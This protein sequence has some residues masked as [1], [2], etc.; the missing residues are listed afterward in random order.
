MLGRIFGIA[1]R[2]IVRTCVSARPQQNFNLSTAQFAACRKFSVTRPTRAEAVK[3][4]A[5][6][7]DIDEEEAEDEAEDEKGEIYHEAPIKLYS[8]SGEIATYIFQSIEDVNVTVRVVNELHTFYESTLETPELEEFLNDPALK[9]DT[10]Y[11]LLYKYGDLVELSPYTRDILDDL[12]EA[13]QFG[14]LRAVAE[15]LL[16]LLR[17]Y[18]SL[19]PVDVYVAKEG[20]DVPDD[21]EIIEK[22]EL[23]EDT[24][25]EVRQH[26]DKS[27][28]GGVILKTKDYIYDDSLSTDIKKLNAAIALRNSHVFELWKSKAFQD[29]GL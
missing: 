9:L 25:L 6:D 13:R 10:A 1:H 19:V 7:E 14:K 26:V 20:Q 27:I 4:V 2:T 15:D 28:L 21:E 5:E 23:P 8:K 18:F 11:K 3:T 24:V 16:T 29:L 17:E 22:L 12:A